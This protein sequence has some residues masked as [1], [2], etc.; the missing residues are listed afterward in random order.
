VL[1]DGETLAA[2]LWR[3]M[4]DL[5]SADSLMAQQFVGEQEYIQARAARTGQNPT[6]TILPFTEV[7]EVFDELDRCIRESVP[8]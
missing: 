8:E 6:V 5:P 2:L 7:Q 1:A 4:G 3:I